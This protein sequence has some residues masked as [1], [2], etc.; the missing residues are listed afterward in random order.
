MSIPYNIYV[1]Y[2]QYFLQPLY[3]VKIIVTRNEFR[4]FNQKKIVEDNLLIILRLWYEIIIHKT[5]PIYF[6]V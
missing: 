5:F 1:L 2:K 3:F 4:Y 6:Y